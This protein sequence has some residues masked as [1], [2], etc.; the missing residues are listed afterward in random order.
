MTTDEM[1]ALCKRHT[2]FTWSRQD[3]VQPLPMARGEG[4]HIVTPDGERLLDFNSQTMSMHVGHAH[5][6]L[7][8]ALHA[9]VDELAYAMP[10]AAT[11]VRARLGKLLAEIMPGDLDTFLF[12]LGGADANE[13]AV[14]LA[15]LYTGRHKILSRYRSYHGATLAML[16]LTGDPRRW[17][18]EPGPPGFVKVLDPEPYHYSFGATEAERTEQNLR[19]LE[20]VITYEGPQNIAAMVIETVT[21]T[22]GVLPPP[23]GYLRGLRELLERHGILLICDEVM[24]G[25]GRTGKMFAFEHGGIIPDLVTL[26][27]GL[28]SSY[29][30]LGAVAMRAPIAEHFRDVYYPGGLTYNSHPLCLAA[31][32]ANI[33][34]L[35]DDGLVERAAALAPLLRELLGGLQADH[36][37]VAA[38]R[39]IG[40]F[41][42]IDLRKNAAGE[43]LA[44]YN[45]S[46]PEMTAVAKAMREG[47]LYAY[48]HWASIMCCP[49]LII[50]EDQLRQGVAIIGRALEVADASYDDG[51]SA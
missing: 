3:S 32:E 47:G 4:V 19:Y 25:F 26:A 5:P 15:R 20:E 29:A 49:P 46:S 48:V 45:S 17:V 14:R 18:A 35:L 1:V 13:N 34:T 38:T 24:A 30:P 31:A 33:R 27:K 39:S 12:T 41:G 44:P 21:G 11:A 9:Q 50:S 37:S 6:R 43:P 16:N 36:P 22:N 40:L 10:G 8:E 7:L 51:R 42:M 2:F 28:T 23:G